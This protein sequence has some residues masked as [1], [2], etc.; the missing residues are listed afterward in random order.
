MTP[1]KSTGSTGRRLKKACEA[2]L[3]EHHHHHH[4]KSNRTKSSSD[5][6]RI[7]LQA[8]G[9]EAWKS[10]NETA[11][12]SYKKKL[13]LSYAAVVKWATG[14]QALSKTRRTVATRTSGQSGN[15]VL[16]NGRNNGDFTFSVSLMLPCKLQVASDYHEMKP[17]K[18]GNFNMRLY[19]WQ[20]LAWSR[21]EASYDIGSLLN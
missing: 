4:H 10:N 13:W 21:F 16:R 15:L 20:L 6:L 19:S 7:S 8:T 2:A 17:R 12:Q 9:P 5:Y 1:D 18:K 14:R 3:T 11:N